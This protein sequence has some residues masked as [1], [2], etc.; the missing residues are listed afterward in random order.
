MPSQRYL[1]PPFASEL[2]NGSGY[3]RGYFSG[4]QLPDDRGIKPDLSE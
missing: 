4:G 2:Q 1:I 3:E